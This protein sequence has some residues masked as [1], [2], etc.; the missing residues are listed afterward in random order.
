MPP[1]DLE[2]CQITQDER[3][4]EVKFQALVLAYTQVTS[5][6]S[7]VINYCPERTVTSENA[8]A[9]KLS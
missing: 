1:N 4:S 3:E 6:M 8:P 7:T 5:A 9:V 2:Y